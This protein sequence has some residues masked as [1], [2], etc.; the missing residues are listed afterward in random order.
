MLSIKI[1]ICFEKISESNRIFNCID[2]FNLRI[3]VGGDQ[4]IMVE[5]YQMNSKVVY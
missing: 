1:C 4:M 5:D 2:A 3:V